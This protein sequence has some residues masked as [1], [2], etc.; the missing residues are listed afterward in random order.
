[1]SVFHFKQFSIAQGNSAMKVSTDA[2][3]FGAVVATLPCAKIAKR[4]LDI[5]TGT[6]LL[7]LMMAQANEKATIHA[8]E[9]DTGALEDARHNFQSSP[10]GKNLILVPT[11]AKEFSNNIKY[12]LIISNPPFYEQQLTGPNIAK[13]LAHH[14]AGLTLVALL[15]ISFGLLNENGSLAVLLPYYRKHEC[16]DLARQKGLFPAT[17]FEV[18]HSIYREAKRVILVFTNHQTNIEPQD[19]E[20]I[21]YEKEGDYTPEFLDYLKPYYL[22]L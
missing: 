7:S 14:E 8:L 18:K 13:N 4:I 12:D 19:K 22:N 6:G 1:M 5:G 11:D 15:E 21:I 3:L 17:I 16:I 9:I 10:W 2:C 20:I